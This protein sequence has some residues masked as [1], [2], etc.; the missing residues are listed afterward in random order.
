MSFLGNFLWPIGK[1]LRQSQHLLKQYGLLYSQKDIEFVV[2]KQRR[3]ITFKNY[4]K[5]IVNKENYIP[6]VFHCI[7]K[8]YRVY[9]KF[10]KMNLLVIYES[11]YLIHFTKFLMSTRKYNDGLN[12]LSKWW[13]IFHELIKTKKLHD[14]YYVN[15]LIWLTW[16]NLQKLPQTTRIMAIYPT[17]VT[18]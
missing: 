16:S 10:S 12:P 5:W 15:A 2:Y 18:N 13:L 6:D 7:F 9:Q 11:T 8:T 17:N 1:F 14:L 3:S 4:R